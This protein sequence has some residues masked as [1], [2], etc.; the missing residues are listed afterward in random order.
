MKKVLVLLLAVLAL[1]LSSAQGKGVYLNGKKINT[2]K[3]N[4]IKASAGASMFIV[5]IGSIKTRAIISGKTSRDVVDAKEL[6]FEFNFGSESRDDFSTS[7]IVTVNSPNDL[8]LFKLKTKK[9]SRELLVGTMGTFSGASVGL[10]SDDAIQYDYSE[11]STG[12]YE[13]TLPSNLP[14]GEYAFVSNQWMGVASLLWTF[15]VENSDYI[16]PLEQSKIDKAKRKATRKSK[17]NN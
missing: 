17:G 16:S 10:N 4:S 12:V 15:T 9:N 1:N 7:S 11:L 5:G 2:T 13:V 6:N 3:V 8:Y 14:N